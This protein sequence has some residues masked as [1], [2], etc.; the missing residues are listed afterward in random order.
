MNDWEI[1]I[2]KFDSINRKFGVFS[3]HVI[4][5]VPYV[6]EKNDRMFSRFFYVVKGK[7]IFNKGT[8][9]MLEVS[10]GELAYLPNDVTYKSEWD[11]SEEG[12][13]ISLHFMLDEFYVRLPDRICTVAHDKHGIYLEM[14]SELLDVWN[15]GALGY[16]FEIL[17][18]IYKVM[19]QVFSDITYKKIKNKNSIIYKG[20]LY[21]ENHYLENVTVAQLAS[22][23]NTSEGNFRRLFRKYKK[24]PPVTYRNYLRI[25]KALVLIETGE[26]NVS[27]AA[28]A[29]NIDDICYFHKMFRSFFGCTPKQYLKSEKSNSSDSD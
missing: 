22:I 13:Y 10:S 29:V 9:E 18:G 24:M 8:E 16:E 2:T 4:P 27:E 19:Y 14:F 23:C 1:K 12:E 26:Y 11:I 21:L 3:D 5:P 25:K 6:C 28:Q 20:I 7:I 17:S 15:K